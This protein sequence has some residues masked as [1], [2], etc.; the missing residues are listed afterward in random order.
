[1]KCEVCYRHCNINEGGTGFCGVRTCKDGKV[2]PGNYGKITAVALDP[3]EKKPLKMFMSGSKILSIGSYGCN[4]RCPFCQNYDISWGREIKS[5]AGRTQIISPK[6]I[7]LKAID[8][9]S[10]GNIG[11]AFTYNEPLLGYEF[12][13]D[14]ARLAKE[15]DL[16]TVLVTNGTASEQVYEEIA[17]Y[18]DAMNIDIKSFSSDFYRNLINGDLAMIKDFIDR[19]VK[20]CHVEL[21]NLIIPGENDSEEE[22][23]ELSKWIHFLEIKTGKK[24]PLHVT[25]FFPKFHM[26][27][28]DATNIDLIYRLADV[29][30]ENLEFV[31]EG[32]V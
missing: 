13:R 27:D 2:I 3:I 16:V 5:F 22:M 28:R 4:L 14:T 7:V 19:S 21:T 11:I 25:R 32:N 6:D 26:T 29:A 17:P 15:K 1:M 12:V 8:L 24:I 9:K 23:R 10:Q 31:F 30:R 18:I 20:S